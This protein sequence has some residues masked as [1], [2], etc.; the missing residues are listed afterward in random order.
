MNQTEKFMSAVQ[1]AG[2]NGVTTEELRK[3]LKGK[4]QSVHSAAHA[5]KKNGFK[6]INTRG[7][8][9]Y[10]GE[11]VQSTALVPSQPT[12]GVFPTSILGI[13]MSQSVLSRMDAASR[14]D[15][16]EQLRRAQLHVGIAKSIIES[17]KFAKE[18]E[19]KI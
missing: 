15:L 14:A 10:K 19:E 9:L 16:V 17:H 8:Y 5:A 18:L 12:D 7:I 3:L 13:H 4:E 1:A 6:F 11:P 2:M